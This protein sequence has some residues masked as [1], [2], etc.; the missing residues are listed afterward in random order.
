[1]KMKKAFGAVTMAA[2]L[3]LLGALL[4]PLA[5]QADTP[6]ASSPPSTSTAS[7]TAGPTT[8]SIPGTTHPSSTAAPEAP[9]TPTSTPTPST[10]PAPHVDGAAPQTGAPTPG[11]TNSAPI[12]SPAPPAVSSLLATAP[13][14][15]SSSPID[16]TA[17]GIFTV[18]ASVNKVGLTDG[19]YVKKS[20]IGTFSK[21]VP[22]EIAGSTTV[23]D[24]RSRFSSNNPLFGDFTYQIVMMGVRT[25][26]WIRAHTTTTDL[27]GLGGSCYVYAGD[28][29]DADVP[30]ADPAPF[31]CDSTVVQDFS[32]Y[33]EYYHGSVNFSVA[34]NNQAEVQGSVQTKG[35]VSLES[36]YW[37]ISTPYADLG[38][39]SVAANGST[40]FD[41]VYR[42]GDVLPVHPHMAKGTFIYQISTNGL[43]QN[44]WVLGWASNDRQSTFR[45]DAECYIFAQNPLG[46]LDNPSSMKPLTVAPFTCTAQ[47]FN[48]PDRGHWVVDFVI[49]PTVVRVLPDNGQNR[50]L[51]NSLVQAHCTTEDLSDCGL[52][53]AKVTRAQSDPV[54]A[55]A[56]YQNAS[57]DVT[58]H[59]HTAISKTIGTTN[60]VGVKVGVS[61][62]FMGLFEASIEA[63]YSYTLTDS[64][65]VTDDK[66]FDVPPL[67]TAWFEASTEVATA[68]GDL[69]I[70]DNGVVYK[71]INAGAVFP[72]KNGA[73]SVTF[74]T[75]GY[76][77]NPQKKAMLSGSVRTNTGTTLST[78]LS[79]INGAY[80][81]PLTDIAS[82]VRDVSTAGAPSVGENSSTTWSTVET[83]VDPH[84]TGGAEAEGSFTYQI[85]ADGAPTAYWVT[86]TG[87][88]WAADGNPAA[89][90][91]IYHGNPADGGAAA[92]DAPYQCLTTIGPADENGTVNATFTVSPRSASVTPDGTTTPPAEIAPV[93]STTDMLSPSAPASSRISGLASTGSSLDPAPYLAGLLALL[94]GAGLLIAARNPQHRKESRR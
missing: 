67:T 35:G 74:H 53:L 78:P 34:L 54:M 62:K 60:T 39:P 22:I 25:G 70:R 93:G 11:D 56:L 30:A 55:S 64:T 63:S 28:P 6:A 86:G 26:Y 4:M 48:R 77:P 36:G 84:D 61:A 73:S 29:G 23:Y 12:D 82:P 90:C 31:T 76:V 13:N 18:T 17:D 45:H 24:A 1:M 40:S 89:A 3:S 47:G 20:S 83:I 32:P 91:V 14:A 19:H 49:A 21:S 69:Y 9:A 68:V 52:V 51:R 27:L 79:L 5:A 37:E 44:Y 85:A 38:A 75:D 8:P 87:D 42:D 46:Y 65:T 94:L 59:E 80:A 7:T 58:L 92:A 57:A 2:S 41:S 81:L 72:I 33:F 50:S 10:P 66:N 71:V 88:T 16:F 43:K 15:V